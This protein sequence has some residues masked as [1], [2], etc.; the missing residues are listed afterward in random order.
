[1]SAD[2]PASNSDASVLGAVNSQ[3]IAVEKSADRELSNDSRTG[4][5]MVQPCDLSLI[6]GSE[7]IGRG[8]YI[9]PRQPYDLKDFVFSLDKADPA[10]YMSRD[11]G[12]GSSPGRF[13]VPAGCEVN[14]APPLPTDQ[15][16]GH[17]MIEES[18]SRFG[19]QLSVDVN[20]SVSSKV[21]SIDATAF[22]ASSLQS[23]ED[24]Y[25]AIRNSF[26]PL[27]SVYSPK[28]NKGHASEKLKDLES[29]LPD[30]PYNPIYREKYAEVFD[31]LGTHYV[32]SC[33]VGGKAS[34]IFVVNKSSQLS[35]DEVRASIQAAVGG[36]MNTNVSG[37]KATSSETFQSN[38][39][40]T[41]FGC[42]GDSTLLAQ[43]STLNHDIYN[44]WVKSVKAN[45]EIIQF[46]LA[47][48]WTLF[49]NPVKADALMQAYI[50]ESI[51]TPLSAIVPYTFGSDLDNSRK[52][53]LLFVKDGEA[54]D[55]DTLQQSG[56]SRVNVLSYYFAGMDFRQPDKLVNELA[57][58]DTSKERATNLELPPSAN[59]FLRELAGLPPE[60]ISE[61]SAPARKTTGSASGGKA[62]KSSDHIRP[63]ISPSA[64]GVS[65]KDLAQS[66]FNRL[67]A[68]DI[69]IYEQPQLAGSFKRL[70]E[71]AKEE[72][73]ELKFLIDEYENKRG[74][75]SCLP[76]KSNIRCLNR[77]LLEFAFNRNGE[78]L[79]E[80]R[81]LKMSLARYA[82]C[83]RDS[84]Y[85]DFSR[86]HA[87]FSTRGF[88][89]EMDNY[90]FLFRWQQYIRISVDESG[91]NRVDPDYP[92]NIVEGG[93][94]GVD[95]D[96]IDATLAVAPDKVYFFRGSE[97]VCTTLKDGAVIKSFK[98]TIK[99]HWPGVAFDKIDT[100]VY[101][102]N[103]K[104]YFF[105]EDK[106]IRF[107]MA[108]G[109]ADAGYPKFLTSN[110]VDNWEFF[111]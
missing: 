29:E 51:F 25:Y 76:N 95:F 46:G 81:P 61:Q 5:S 75:K 19:K 99:D 77:R 68:Q 66:I 6:P 14:D 107:D 104:A 109:R 73:P 34:L 80:P 72:D 108:I 11:N 31:A 52:S 4:G 27:W 89:G 2:D 41:V 94:V 57:N 13:C 103:S 74:S 53:V 93:W 50:Q 20:A 79:V 97:F 88:G 67:L 82:R 65:N 15:S 9:R 78:T 98:G 12:D 92:K 63:D 1:M 58:L 38:S 23:N 49:Q 22:Q 10:V 87:A 47:G 59:P 106:Y 17:T 84:R 110:Y 56:Q 26:I 8:I 3:S 44:Q 55:Y 36:L 101:W 105:S 83:L 91:K 40:C 111:G 7:V 43:L 16:L 30:G 64:L 60:P 100:A 85:S 33:W 71:Q 37:S 24:A 39:S 35:K 45:P 70:K 48:I 90:I 86:P 42:G 62:P 69:P 28:Q 96:R 32:R 18:W 102:G 54:F 21:F